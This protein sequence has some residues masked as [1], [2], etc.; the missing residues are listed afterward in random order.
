[1]SVAGRGA[2]RVLVWGS[3]GMQGEEHLYGIDLTL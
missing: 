2:C 3:Y 1:M